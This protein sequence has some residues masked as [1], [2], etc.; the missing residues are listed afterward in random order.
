MPVSSISAADYDSSIVAHFPL[1]GNTTDA[2]GNGHTLNINSCTW[3]DNSLFLAGGARSTNRFATFENDLLKNMNSVTMS[4]WINNNS[5]MGNL[6]GFFFGSAAGTGGSGMPK[7]YVLLVPCSPSGVYKTRMVNA[8]VTSNPYNSEVGYQG[9]DT[10]QYFGKW[11]QYSIVITPTDI[12]AYINGQR[13]GS[14]THTRQI[15]SY[16]GTLSAF[17]GASNY[18]SDSLFSGYFRD[19]RFYSTSLSDSQMNDLYL[20][21]SAEYLTIKSSFSD[22]E[23]L[24]ASYAGFPI[25]W[26]SSDGLSVVDGKIVA[27][28][29][30]IKQVRLTATYGTFV[31]SF[32]ITIL[33]KNPLAKP[34]IFAYVDSSQ[35]SAVGYSMHY[36]ILADNVVT[37]L[38]FG[39]GVLFAPADFTTGQN[40]ASLTYIQDYDPNLTSYYYGGKRSLNNPWIF[41]MADGKY[42]VV[43]EQRAYDDSLP[44]GY[45]RTLFF[46]TSENLIDFTFKG[47]ISPLATE[48]VSKPQVTYDNGA[49]YITWEAGSAIREVR[50]TDF[51]EFSNYV[52]N[53]TRARVSVPTVRNGVSCAFE[54]SA[55][56]YD[57]ILKKLSPITNTGADNTEVVELDLGESFT[58]DDLPKTFKAYYS[59]SSEVDMPIKWDA[60]VLNSL[61]T[62]AAGVYTLTGTAAYDTYAFPFIN[63]RADPCVKFYNGY[64]YFIAT[65]DTSGSGDNSYQQ[66]I[67]IRRATTLSELATA[68]EYTIL[69]RSYAQSS[70]KWAP[71]LHIIN[72]T[73]SV[74]LAIGQGGSASWNR[75]HAHIMTLKEGGDPLV[76]ADWNTP[77]T[78]KRPGGTQQL[79]TNVN[80]ITIDMTYLQDGENHYYIW[81]QRFVRSGTG[82]ADIYIAKF[83]PANPSVL[84]SDPVCLL[85]PTYGWERPGDSRVSE[86]PFVLKHDGRLFLTYSGGAVDQTYVVAM[87]EG[88]PGTDLTDLA[89]WKLTGYPLLTSN[90]VVG[91]YGPG[92]NAYTTDEFGRDVNVYH[93]RT[94]TGTGARHAGLR[95]VHWAFDGTPVLYMTADRQLKSQ[96]RQFK[97]I[98]KVFVDSDVDAD[99]ASLS[100]TNINDVRG[101]LYLPNKGILGSSVIWKSS[102]PSVISSTGEVKRPAYGEDDVIVKLTA[103]VT[104]G[105]DSVEREFDATVRSMPRKTPYSGYLLGYFLANTVSGEN[106]RMSVS[107]GNSPTSWTRIL[108]DD[109]DILFTSLLGEMG[110]R[111]PFIIR[112]PEGDRFYMIA[113]DLSIGRNG[114]WTRA[115]TRGSLYIEVWESTDL[116]NWS[117]QRH[118]KVSPDTAGNTW[119]PEAFWD[120]SIGAYV[121]FWAS[122]IYPEG[123]ARSSAT[124]NRMMFCT[125]RDFVTFT[126]PQIWQN[127]TIATIDTT[128]IKENDMYYRFTKNESGYNSRTNPYGKDIFLEKGANLRDT[129]L[130]NW[131]L[132]ANNVSRRIWNNGT[133]STGYEGPVIFRANPGDSRGNGFYYMP[134]NNGGAGYRLAFIPDLNSTENWSQVPGVNWG[135]T[136]TIHHGTVANI[137]ETERQALLGSVYQVPTTTTIN[138]PSAAY[139]GIRSKV[140]I[141]VVAADGGEVAGEVEVS[142]NNQVVTLKLVNGQA[143]LKLPADLPIGNYEITAKYLGLGEVAAS[144]SK[145]TLTISE[146]PDITPPVGTSDKGDGTY[147]NP[148][149]FGDVPDLDIIRVGDAYWMASTSMHMAPGVPIMR[150]YDLVN[151]ETVSYCYLA[152]EDSNAA[153]LSGTSQMYSNGTWAASMRYKD[154]MFYLVVPSPTSNKTYFF[155]NDDPANKPWTRYEYGTRYHDCG[156][157][158]DDDGRNWLVYNA[159]PLYIIELNDTVTGVKAGATRRTILSNIHA[160]NPITGIRPTSGLAEGAHIQKIDGKYYIFCI[161]W[162]SG[163]PRTEV[164]HRSDSLDGPWEDKVV[165]M[166]AIRHDG[167]STGS[168]GPAQ[169]G[170]VDDSEGNYWGFIFRDSG[171]VGRAPWVMPITWTDGWPMYGSN[172]DGT[173]SYTNLSRGGEKP[174]ASISYASVVSSD[175]FYNNAP[176][177][178]YLDSVKP[179]RVSYATGEYDDNGSYLD[180]AWQW[181]HNPDNRYWTLTERAGWLRLKAMLNSNATRNILNARNTLTQRVFG[182]YSSA[183][184]CIDVSNMTNGDEAGLSLFAAKYGSIGVKMESGVKYLVTTLANTWTSGHATDRGVESARITLNGDKVYLKAEGDFFTSNNA[185]TNYGDFF[186]SYD[187]ITWT[188]LGGTLNMIYSTGNHFMGYRFG[189]YN[190]AKT[191]IG[192]YVDF[193][194]F[195]L[196]DKLTAATAPTTLGA[197]MNNML[198][199]AGE[200]LSIPIMLDPLPAGDYTEIAASFNIPDGLTVEDVVFGSDV[201]G[202]LGY[203]VKGNQLEIVA[204][205]SKANFQPTARAI[206]ATIKLSSETLSALPAVLTLAPDYINVR[207]GAYVAYNLDGVGAKITLIDDISVNADYIISTRILTSPTVPSDITAEFYVKATRVGASDKVRLIYGVYDQSEKLL[208]TGGDL[209]TISEPYLEQTIPV[210]VP[211]GVDPSKIKVRAFVWSEDYVPLAIAIEK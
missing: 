158:L 32:D 46:W 177:P 28:N 166:E 174:V 59:D 21:E 2:S 99:A 173:G 186:Y 64:Y 75:Q 119:A 210:V 128:V 3:V 202:T 48:A 49:Y 129:N 178:A 51:V 97:M 56:A 40:T 132:I 4:M 23:Q 155:H 196:Y 76:A 111:D 211:S 34:T 1:R 67:R 163:Q 62:N 208:S 184:T 16:A 170:I 7:D 29:D 206:F 122:C 176:R 14:A 50:T 171:P 95:T 201:K 73:L 44:S 10:T 175:E 156:L 205:G 107:Q 159:N 83:D 145:K 126:E 80:G 87:L 92:H 31:K 65:Y 94:D 85:R 193:D 131:E 63:D 38:N 138:I 194:F 15:S 17:L 150:S 125:T 22:G 180:M 181:N 70:L 9:T 25:S 104:N 200:S 18:T 8:D 209:I 54:I 114:N 88:N 198:V 52:A 118:V 82:T 187:G 41:N 39:D 91:E 169:G 127:R 74:L 37:P 45:D 110:L 42:G 106:I 20:R 188:K 96:Y 143:I 147:T 120:D 190:F 71:E 81:N 204:T 135:T 153:K 98:V 101:N 78:I 6:T 5:S 55:S 124:P 160:T 154:G 60:N 167:V 43:A 116:V 11:A 164:C 121:V 113:T 149:I 185:A 152:M 30:E 134:D 182:P 93:A 157:L 72:G 108:K 199:K 179:T 58:A 13:V 136:A 53:S 165:A 172:A 26:T 103:T 146:T 100:V 112:S 137:T 161:T 47:A 191:A 61:N 84:T 207:G 148:F 24:P 183:V 105:Q 27:S 19:V 168:D 86:G 36:A 102:L 142:Y 12:I 79:Q 139:F 162:P 195:R 189:L 151:W 192:G 68:T 203:S 57:Y 69:P 90:K 66:S 89:N 130:D 144:Q 123:S 197:A 77:V 133:G 35:S 115:Q 117:E 140:T 109:S 141:D 33:P